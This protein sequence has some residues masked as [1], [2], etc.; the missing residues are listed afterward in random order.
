MPYRNSGGATHIRNEKKKEDL[1]D[2]SGNPKCSASSASRTR[3]Y[4]DLG[5]LSGSVRVIL[6]SNE[7]CVYNLF[8]SRLWGLVEQD[9]IRLTLACKDCSPLSKMI[10][11][12]R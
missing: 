5:H 6:T 2:P 7:G 4:A 10:C 9:M 12:D 8:S 11:L 3:P 1:K